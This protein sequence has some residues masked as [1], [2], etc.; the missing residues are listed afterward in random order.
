M[1]STVGSN[2]PGDQLKDTMC[3]EPGY[4]CYANYISHLLDLR[5]VTFNFVEPAHVDALLAVASPIGFLTY[6][7]L[8][9]RYLIAPYGYQAVLLSFRD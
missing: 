3:K 8:R 2:D 5:G 7:P 9:P 1:S 4:V 6:F